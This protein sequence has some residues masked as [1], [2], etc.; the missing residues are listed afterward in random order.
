MVKKNKR[1]KIKKTEIV[2][3]YSGKQIINAKDNYQKRI[4]VSL[5]LSDYLKDHINET[6]AAKIYKHKDI[7]PYLF[8]SIKSENIT[9]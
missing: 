5:Q 7:I 6:K 1:K 4:H 2:G 3:T 9:C 8:Q